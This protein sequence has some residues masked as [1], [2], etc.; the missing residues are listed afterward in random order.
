[1]RVPGACG[2]ALTVDRLDYI[3]AQKIYSVIMPA[4]NAAAHR[5][6]SGCDFY[7]FY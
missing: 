1:M 5:S 2:K 3:G 4:K 6:R 7:L